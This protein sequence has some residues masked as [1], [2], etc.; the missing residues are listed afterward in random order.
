ME[1]SAKPVFY[2]TSTSRWKRFLWGVKILSVFI[3]IGIGCILFSLFH[4]QVFKLPSLREHL[5]L[6]DEGALKIKS[7]DVQAAESEHFAKLA[8]EAKKLKEHNFY[9]RAKIVPGDV[10][11][12]LPIRAGFYVNWDIQ[13]KYSLN[14]NASKLNMVLPEWLFIQDTADVVSIDI[15]IPA[16]EIM[17][18][19]HLAIVPMLTNN[20][21]NIWNGKNVHRIITSP[22]R[23][24]KLIN[25]IIKVL[26]TYSFNGINI[27]FEELNE[28]KTDEYLITFMKEL[29]EKLNSKGY[30]VTQDISPFNEDYNVEELAKY[31]D[32]LFLM[33]YDQNNSETTCGPVAAQLWLEAA[34][35]DLDKKVPS[36]KVVLCIAAF[37]YDWQEGYQGEDVT[38]QE[39][40]STA[41]ES[42]G[43]VKFNN[44]TYNLDYTYYDDNDKVHHVF[45]ADAATGFNAM[46]TAADFET[47][48]VAIW[49]LGSEDPRLWKFYNRNLSVK[50]LENNPFDSNILQQEQASYSVDYVGAGEILNILS[51]PQ[52]GKLNIEYDKK[53]N[54][55][56]EEEYISLPSGYVINKAG[57]KPKQIVMTFDDG[58]DERYTPDILDILKTN[59]VP[60]VFFITGINA[61]QNLPLVKRLYNEGHEIGNHTFLHP[62]LELASDDRLKLELRSTGY[63][64]ESIT[65]HATMLFR[66]PYNTDAEPTN[67]VQIKPLYTAKQEGYLT[68][69]SSIDP[70]DWQEGVTPDTIV[71]RAIK[72]Q[73]LGNILLMHDAGGNRESTVKALPRIIEYY[74]MHGYKFVSLAS[75][76]DKTRD[77][78]MPKAIGSFDNYLQSADAT[79]FSVGYYFNRIVSAIFF[80][81]MI[82]S[83]L[84]MK[85]IAFLAIKQRRNSKKKVVNHVNT[86]GHKVSIIVPGY[87]EELT[88]PKTVA[89]LLLS[90]YPDIEIVFVDDGS[91][92]NTFRNIESQ[93]GNH[94]KVKVLTKPNGGKASALNY[95]IGFA[96]GEILVC[97]DADT[98]LNPDAISRMVAYFDDLEVAAVAGNVKVGNRKNLLTCWQSIEYITSQNFD[99]RAFDQLNAIMV[100]PGAIGAFRREAVQKVGMFTTDTLAEDCD[101]TLR[102]LE[103]GYKIRTCNEA[104]AFTEVPETMHML[105]KQ[106]FRWTFGIMQSFW[107]HRGNLFVRRNPNL[108][109]VVLP[110]MLV[111][112][113]ILPLLS[114]LVDITL[115][116]SIFMPKGSIIVILY[117]AYYLLDLGI[118]ILA[119]R[120]DGEKFTPRE[121]V[122]L[123]LQRIIYRQLLWYVL[124][125]G[126]LRAMKGELAAWGFLK[127]TG[128]VEAVLIK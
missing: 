121:A 63:I 9:K 12:Y 4:K 54:L 103:A 34:L 52:A 40:I 124:A 101:L 78:I 108:G 14:Q 68:I 114:P 97:I 19:N 49:R 95:G 106:R 74:K 41:L 25:S 98:V 48:G 51:I 2:S 82:L 7:A 105:L 47:S 110:N 86:G 85:S 73:L 109:W 26:D 1:T 94:P 83:L 128:S 8:I 32:F 123:F 115:L 17:R 58:P 70:Q 87:N 56:A 23:R 104:L 66:P 76:M 22:E 91:K 36:D 127:R 55:I 71:A 118:S 30:L 64:I 57:E 15:D 99:R 96:S 72:Q 100:V 18:S 13:S 77:D 50:D 102:L 46:R 11:K 27:D 75:L 111:F 43:K 31:N 5:I 81:A 28:E 84:K 112:Q 89:N 33:G 61:E 67:P 88:A 16:L 44:N 90:D 53:E 125:K 116:A 65:G 79:V 10:K 3:V 93:Y 39:A 117:F 24:T 20:F 45:F 62:N 59:N 42:E 35:G 6:L 107:K 120:F 80:M 60:A 37:G 69:G 119:F 38:Y 122:N 29:H 21:N 126:Y 113:L 92:D